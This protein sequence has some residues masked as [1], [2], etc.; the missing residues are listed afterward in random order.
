[1]LDF[2]VDFEKACDSVDWGFLEYMIRRV[3]MC[4]KWIA[5]IKVR[6]FAGNISILVNGSQ[7]RK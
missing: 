3:G 2:E 5:W 4:D 7:R 6:V 1:M